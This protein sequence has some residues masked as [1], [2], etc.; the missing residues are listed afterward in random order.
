MPDYDAIIIGGGPSG[1]NAGLYLSRARIRTLLLEQ[2]S[3]GGK[4]KNLELIENYAGFANGIDGA[5]LANEMH[6][7]AVKYGL[8]VEIGKAVELEMYSSSKCIICENG[9]SYTSTALII[10]GGSQPKKLNVPGEDT[11]LGKGVFTCAFCDGGQFQNQLVVVCGGG[12]AGITEAIYMSKIASKVIVMEAMP[13]LTAS[14]ILQERVKNNPIIEVMCGVKID[15]VMGNGR[16]QAVEYTEMNRGSKGILKAEGL[17]VYIGLDPNT[18]YLEG[19]IPLD[20]QGQIIVNEK[21][22]TEIPFVFAAGDIRSESPGQI[23]SAVG[24]GTIAAISAIKLLH[25][26]DDSAN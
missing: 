3:Y 16:M 1:L 15:A 10:A 4:I 22:E 21:M 14:A 17:L 7:Q 24:D 2:N 6:N 25:N 26:R 5:S 20:K 19:M 11:F 18:K 23:S 9:K 8:Q 12:D 13:A